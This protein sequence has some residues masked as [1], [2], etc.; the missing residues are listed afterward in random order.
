MLKSVLLF[1]ARLICRFVG[2]ERTFF[3]SLLDADE[4]ASSAAE[5]EVAKASGWHVDSFASNDEENTH[6]HNNT[7]SAHSSKSRR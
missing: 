4:S 6:A 1:V 7:T 5:E 2:C 3:A